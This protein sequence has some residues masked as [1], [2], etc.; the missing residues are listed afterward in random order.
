MLKVQCKYLY[1]AQIIS[2]LAG[3]YF[4]KYM[5]FILFFKKIQRKLHMKDLTVRFDYN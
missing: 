2:A 5:K 1:I 3:F 4:K